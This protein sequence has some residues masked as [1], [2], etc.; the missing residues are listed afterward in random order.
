MMTSLDMHGFSVSLLPVTEAEMAALSAPVP[1]SAW[2]GIEAMVTRADPSGAIE[3]H[4]TGSAAAHQVRERIVDELI[5]LGVPAA[6]GRLPGLDPHRAGDLVDLR[7]PGVFGEEP[8]LRRAL[9]VAHQHSAEAA[10][11]GADQ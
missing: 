9:P 6:D 5:A 2:P 8:R 4:P 3:I 1:L 10:E 7:Q 11:Q